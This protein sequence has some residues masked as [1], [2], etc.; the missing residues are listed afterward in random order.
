M[1]R[2]PISPASFCTSMASSARKTISSAESGAAVEIFLPGILIP[3]HQSKKKNV[4]TASA[5]RKPLRHK[6]RNISKLPLYKSANLFPEPQRA[7]AEEQHGHHRHDP[8][9]WP[10]LKEAGAAQNDGAHEVDE[11]GRREK[12]ADRVKN[13]G[14]RFAWEN[15]AGE[16]HAR[17][18]EGHRHLERLHL[19]LGL[20]GDEQTE[21]EQRENINE[22]GKHHRDYAPG[23]GHREDETHDREQQNRH[24]HSDAKVGHQLS[25]HQTPAAERT[26]EQLLQ[27]PPLA[28][29]HDSHGGGKG[30]SDLQ[31][32]TDHSWHEKV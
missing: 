19:V 1:F 15:E 17:H 20:C 11:I 12:G 7:D 9:R 31:D 29:A 13:P 10:V 6:R 2:S 23:D 14:H 8:K 3:N 22:R 26:H 4:R 16:E 30:G 28:L 18:D 27:R 32:D 21:T 24:E 5:M 25:Q